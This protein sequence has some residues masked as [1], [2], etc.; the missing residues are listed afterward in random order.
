[1]HTKAVKGKDLKPGMI[2]HSYVG[3][4]SF[5]RVIAIQEDL[6]IKGIVCIKIVMEIGND[7]IWPDDIIQVVEPKFV[8]ML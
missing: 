6:D 1:M 5:A 7:Y 4:G 3:N 2:I 8:C